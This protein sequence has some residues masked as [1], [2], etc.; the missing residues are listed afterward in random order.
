M[1]F[2]PF[3]AIIAKKKRFYG[4]LQCRFFCNVCKLWYWK[5]FSSRFETTWRQCRFGYHPKQFLHPNPGEDYYHNLIFLNVLSHEVDPARF[6]GLNHVV[7]SLYLYNSKGLKIGEWLS[8]I[9]LGK[10]GYFFFLRHN[11]VAQN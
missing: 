4:W 5:I 11:C 1:H 3:F 10:I 2:Y 9:S 7:K 8:K 6:H